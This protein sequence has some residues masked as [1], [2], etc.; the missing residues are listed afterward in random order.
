[1]EEISYFLVGKIEGNAKAVFPAY[2][3]LRPSDATAFRAALTKYLE[4]LRHAALHPKASTDQ[5][6]R[7]G[8]T[9]KQSP[10]S[11][12]PGVELAWWWKDVMV[13]KSLLEECSGDKFE[14]LMLALST[15]ALVKGLD[16]QSVPSAIDASSMAPV[17]V[18]DS[19][20]T[21]HRHTEAD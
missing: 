21:W 14:R 18:S 8:K 20:D 7:L 11:G 5:L 1:M 6:R 3:C 2:P 13:R 10:S 19:I 12:T 9:V 17:S 16:G 15:H 4:T